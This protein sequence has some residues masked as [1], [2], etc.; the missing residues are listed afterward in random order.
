MLIP[1]NYC[2]INFRYTGLA[3]PT[4]AENV[5]GGF[6]GSG[7]LDPTEV[8]NLAIDAWT[9]N[10]AALV[11]NDLTLSSVLVKFGPNADGPAV[12]VGSG[13]TG[14][15]GG[16]GM[17]PQNALLVNKLTNFGGRKGRGR[18]FLPGI[19]EGTADESGVI[20]GGTVAIY[21]AGFDGFLADMIS[22]GVQPKLLHNDATTP[23]DI[24]SFAVQSLMA[25]IKA[26]IRR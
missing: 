16:A 22:G 6:Q 15:A 17:T 1:E 20:A 5:I 11:V 12:E 21:Q 19:T 18:L 8:A 10:I 9:D 13:Q 4:G 14:A 3:C 24:T 25:T 26:R 23:Y 2:Q 7:G